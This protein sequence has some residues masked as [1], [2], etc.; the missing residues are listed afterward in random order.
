DL[1]TAPQYKTYMSILGYSLEDIERY[2]T[3]AIQA[4]AAPTI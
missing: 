3:L 4:K 2:F 1:L